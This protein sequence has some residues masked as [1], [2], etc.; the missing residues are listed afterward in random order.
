MSSD[1]PLVQIDLSPEYKRNLRDL[2]KRYRSI[3]FDTQN[4]LEQIQAG[5][6]VGDRLVGLGEEYVVIKVR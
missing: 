3:R 1:S 5:N 6:F 4:V 2:S